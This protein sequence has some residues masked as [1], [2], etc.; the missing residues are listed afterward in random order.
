MLS[1]R[2]QRQIDRLLDQA[3]EAIAQLNW[4]VVRDRAL[5]VLALDPE[6]VDAR[7]YV[8]A[9]A[10]ALPITMM[11]DAEDP[12]PSPTHPRGQSG[13][14]A[15][16]S[17][18]N[19]RYQVTKLL[20]E[21]GKKRV[22][23]A[24]D[25]LLDRDVAFALIKTEGLDDAGRQR[26]RREAQAMGRLGSHPNIVIV[27]DLG[28]EQGQPYLVT[29]LMPGGD[30]VSILAAAPEHRLPLEQ[31]LAL[32]QQLCRALEHAHGRA[33][34]HRDLKPGNIW[35]TAD[36]TAK[37]GDFGLAVALDQTRHTQPGMMVGT[38][39]YMAPEQAIGGVVD[40]HADLYALGCVLYEL[41]CGRPPF[42]GEESVA[43][44]TQ[45]LNTPPV[46]PTW[47]RPDCPPGLE[48]LILRL[49]E[50]DASKRPGSA[51]DVGAALGSVAL[52]D[53]GGVQ[54]PPD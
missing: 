49:L 31:V 35:I 15:P 8:D 47:H 48:A 20:G 54:H 39:S 36:G 44:I 18:A 23:L 4:S 29:E 27:H 37:L 16:M 46:H 50:K 7:N 40:A 17:F 14:L 33:L 9:A 41:V 51:A 19:G 3:E 32:A 42:I 1:E 10:R 25:T 6:N 21:G 38:V 2:T 22:Y 30:L 26:I 11:A 28:E 13:S 53:A 45:H 5:A 12:H 52:P 43:I 24:H 34:I